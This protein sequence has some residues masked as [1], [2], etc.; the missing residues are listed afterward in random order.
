MR[1]TDDRQEQRPTPREQGTFGP[2][3]ATSN[4][5]KVEDNRNTK[6]VAPVGNTVTLRSVD[7]VGYGQI[8]FPTLRP[9][10]DWQRPAITIHDDGTPNNPA[11]LDE[12][13]QM[14]ADAISDPWLTARPDPYREQAQARYAK[15]YSV[16]LAD[17][18]AIELLAEYGPWMEIEAGTGW[19][20]RLIQEAGGDI[21]AFRSP[22]NRSS[23]P[24]KTIDWT[25]IIPR[26]PAD[27]V[28]ENS[29]RGLLAVV[30]NDVAAQLLEAIK[31]YQGN[32]LALVQRTAAAGETPSFSDQVLDAVLD[33]NWVLTV[34]HTLPSWEG[35]EHR[36][37]VY[38]RRQ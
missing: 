28:R 20:S 17:P 34:S 3:A 25:L 14:L 5:P 10:E 31:A 13:R 30:R 26:D 16:A 9:V 27:A 4:A 12:V 1:E 29:G 32:T 21:V 35:T 11:N 7:P 19:W 15:R 23:I 6:E 38:T 36:L 18:R 37:T 24:V 33:D 22:Q 2:L 8:Y